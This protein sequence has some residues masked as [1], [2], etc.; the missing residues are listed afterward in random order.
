MPPPRPRSAQNTG[1]T[2]TIK[3]DGTSY[4]LRPNEISALDAAALRRECG[5]SVR[6]LLNA[7]NDDPDLD[8][9]AGLV[10][11]ARRQAGEEVTYTDVA[12]GITYD[13]DLDVDEGPDTDPES[14]SVGG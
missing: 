13:S 3:L 12:Q 14:E 2:V 8:V 11:L 7:A 5:M 9:L 4:V 6:G 10:W 1:V